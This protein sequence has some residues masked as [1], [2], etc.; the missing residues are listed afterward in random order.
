MIDSVYQ[1]HLKFG[2][3]LGDKDI[4]MGNYSTLEFRANFM[5]EE[6]LE[7]L[8]AVG[9]NDRVKAFDAL[10]D[11]VYV[12]QGTALFMGISPDQWH[13][14]FAAVQKANMSKERAQ[15]P[16]QSKRGS[17]FDVIKPPGWQGPE[18]ALRRILSCDSADD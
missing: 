3:P 5:K 9:N 14:G 13:D 1:F 6:F 10:L 16:N 17:T 7:F 4:L 15:T 2:L 11:L 8:D 12:V 18:E